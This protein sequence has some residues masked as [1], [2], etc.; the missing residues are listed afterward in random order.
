MNRE[1]YIDLADKVLLAY[2]EE[3]TDEYTRSVTENGICKHG[4]M[5]FY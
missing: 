2:T 3:R 5:S 4:K 1:I